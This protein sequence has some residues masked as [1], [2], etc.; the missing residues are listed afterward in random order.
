M[1]III[2]SVNDMASSILPSNVPSIPLNSP[3]NIAFLFNSQTFSE[4]H[5][6]AQKFLIPFRISI[7]NRVIIAEKNRI[8][9]FKTNKIRWEYALFGMLSSQVDIVNPTLL[10]LLLF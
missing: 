9:F 6:A 10:C 1:V 4:I 5:P 2:F 8:C 3:W 7:E